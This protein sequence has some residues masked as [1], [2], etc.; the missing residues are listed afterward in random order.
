MNIK[1]VIIILL[2]I[3]IFSSI[4][5]VSY[6]IIDQKHN[7]NNNNDSIPTL[8][9]CYTNIT[10]Q[11]AYNIIYYENKNITIIDVP[12]TGITRYNESHLE[13]A[14]MIDDQKY[15]PE[16]IET[17]YN[18]KNDILIYDDDGMGTGIF[19]C[20][21]LINHTYGKIYYL[22][23]GFSEWKKQGFPYWS[24]NEK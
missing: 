5:I 24:W 1:K 21:K 4:I 7:L 10:A 23:G 18:T 22:T 6:I 15:F 12:T 19:Y 3:V 16:G 20:E 17:L 14:I 8:T 2:V 13:D 11:K 9:T